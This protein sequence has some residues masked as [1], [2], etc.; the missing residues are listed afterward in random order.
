LDE[1]APAINIASLV[2]NGQLRL[3]VVGPEERSA[4]PEE[5]RKM[6]ELLEQSLEDGAWGLST[7]LESG[8]ESS[9]TEDEV[10]GLLQSV[11]AA[12]GFHATHTRDRASQ[13]AEA[14]EEGIRTAE[15]ADCRLQ[16]SHL[17]PD[18]GMADLEKCIGVVDS[19]SSR[20]EVSFD[21]HTRLFGIGYLYTALPPSILQGSSDEVAANLRDPEVRRS[22]A[23]FRSV[24]SA[25]GEWGKVILLD[26]EVWP[27]Y[28]RMSIAQIGAALGTGPM[29]TICELLAEASD[30]VSRL[31]VILLTFTGEEQEATFVHPLCVPASDAAALALDGPLAK[32]SFHGAYSWASW[33]FR[34]MVREKRLLSLEQGIH[35]MTGQPAAILGVPKRGLL[36]PG[37][38]AD[39]A[40]F[41]PELYADKETMFD[42]NQPAVGMKNVFVNGTLTL[43]DGALT[44]DRGG[45]VLRRS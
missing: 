27:E 28:S 33:Y 30:D 12:G 8:E 1:G 45:G 9:M 43:R 39:L 42:P 26:N 15:A 36:K 29:D 4:T 38:F 16:V 22:V 41:D 2:P 11:A 17:I 34:Y 40:I 6:R 44:G 37:F 18:G 24:Y 23:S 3:A 21:M 5:Q 25:F 20:A 19:A 7:C 13:A 31:W 35:K 10:A 14:I 32:S